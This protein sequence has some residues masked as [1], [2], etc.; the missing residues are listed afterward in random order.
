MSILLILALFSIAQCSSEFSDRIPMTDE[1]AE[2]IKVLTPTILQNEAQNNTV[3][4][5]TEFEYFNSNGQNIRASIEV[6]NHKYLFIEFYVPPPLSMELPRIIRQENLVSS[7]DLD[8]L[9]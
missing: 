2:H 9:F 1:I 3:F 8:N 5:P 7:E 4:I 6:D